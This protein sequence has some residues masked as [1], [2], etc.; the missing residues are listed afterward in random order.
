[1]QISECNQANA[2]KRRQTSEC[3]QANA[4]SSAGKLLEASKPMLAS[5]SK[6]ASKQARKQT[7][8]C[9]QANARKRLLPGEF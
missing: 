4:N 3:K 7:S 8:G 6:Q 9:K 5:E 1:M 2:S